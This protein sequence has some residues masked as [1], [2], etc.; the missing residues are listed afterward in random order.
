MTS[1]SLQITENDDNK[2]CRLNKRSSETRNIPSTGVFAVVLRQ[3]EYG[4]KS[5]L[6]Y[7]NV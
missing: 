6:K 1:E 4:S 2:V 3:S 5:Y 7:F